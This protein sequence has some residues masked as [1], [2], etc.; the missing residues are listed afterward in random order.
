M[1]QVPASLT[2]GRLAELARIP[3]TTLR[4]YEKRGL[5]DEPP[6]VGGRRLYGPDVLMR[7][8]VIRIC[9][10]AGFTLDEIRSVVDDASPGRATTKR[11]AAERIEAI[12]H[13]LT[14]LDLARSVLAATIDCRCPT[15]EECH[16]GAMDEPVERLQAAGLEPPTDEFTG[17]RPRP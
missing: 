11:I 15:V 10:V 8:M 14:Q 9:R 12:D 6:R 13:Q 5:L 1:D 7:L 16:C 2:I 3:I 17:R 4:Y